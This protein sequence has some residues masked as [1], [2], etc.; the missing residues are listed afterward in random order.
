MLKPSEAHWAAQGIPIAIFFDDGIGAGSSLEAAKSDSFLIRFD[1]SRCGF[2]INQEK[3]KWEPVNKF[4][5]IGHDIDTHKGYIFACSARVEKLCSDL[6]AFCAKLELSAFI[7][8][9]EIASIVGQIIS[10]ASSCGNV[11]QIMT[12]YLHHIINSRS[13]WNSVVFIHDQLRK[14]GV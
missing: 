14:R 10:M 12:R 11:S 7:H 1:L 4:S 6:D 5:W 9:R 3:C 2:E 8:V 13:S